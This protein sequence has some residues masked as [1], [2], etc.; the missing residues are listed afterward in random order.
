MGLETIVTNFPLVRCLSVR[1]LGENLSLDWSKL[2]DVLARVPQVVELEVEAPGLNFDGGARERV[3]SLLS[4]VSESKTIELFSATSCMFESEK[5]CLL[6][7]FTEMVK[8]KE[9]LR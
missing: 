5:K 9:N 2:P 6:P 7:L 4:V 8:K 1:L 3:S